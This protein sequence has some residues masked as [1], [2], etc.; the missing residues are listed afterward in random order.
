MQKVR[1]K[2]AHSLLSVDWQAGSTSAPNATQ[3]PSPSGQLSGSQ[4]NR[5]Q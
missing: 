5:V 1:S 3:T 4:L 2:R